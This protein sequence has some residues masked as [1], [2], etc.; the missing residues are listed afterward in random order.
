MA[1]PHGAFRRGGARLDVEWVSIPARFNGPPG[2][3]N[4]GYTCGLAAG[5]LRS[6]VQVSLRKPPPLDRDLIVR[7][8]AGGR[9]LI[10][11]DEVVAEAAAI[12]R[13][14]ADPP[15]VP[16]IEEARAA[17]DRYPWHSTHIY[18]TCFVCGPGRHAHDG[19]EIFT[20]P[21]AGRDDLFAAGWTP[22]AEWSDESGT[23][24]EE[25]VWAALD[26][27]SAVPVMPA[28]MAPTPAVLARLSASLEAP[29]RAGEAHAIVSWKTGAEGRKLH[30]ASAILDA[31]GRILA[32]ARALWITLDRPMGSGPG[33]TG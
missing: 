20:G 33:E 26:C 18:P 3:A 21:V 1:E 19:L 13:V 8:D 32:R 27:P 11:G 28:D 29:I 12:E 2:S 6:P 25:I 7:G 5:G 30:S 10:D 4:G 16:S 31:D 15:G 23:V 14:A 9:A 17:S 24:R 22:A